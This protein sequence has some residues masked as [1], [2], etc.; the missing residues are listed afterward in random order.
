MTVYTPARPMT[1]DEVAEPRPPWP[2]KIP[3]DLARWIARNWVKKITHHRRILES[4]RDEIWI[5]LHAEKEKKRVPID[6]LEK[7]TELRFTPYCGGLINFVSYPNVTDTIAK[8]D[9]W[10]AKN[11]RDRAEYE[12]L[13]AK[14]EGKAAKETDQ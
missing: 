7:Y 6:F 10:E 11:A 4:F 14:F 5:E 8:I 13:K 3:E 12:R 2:H 1:P 9:A